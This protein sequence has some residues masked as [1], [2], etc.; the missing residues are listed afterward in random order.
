M[1]ANPVVLKWVADE[2]THR[3]LTSR[4]AKAWVLRVRALSRSRNVPLTRSICTVAGESTT[5]PRG[6]RI[7]TESSLPC[8]RS[9]FD[10]LRQA[11]ICRHHQG[12]TSQLP[13]AQRLTIGSSE[14][15][16]IAPPAITAPRQR[17]ALRA[18][19]GQSPRSFDQVGAS[20]PR[21]AGSDEAAGA[22]LHE[23]SPAFAGIDFA[24]GSVFLRDA[25]PKLVDFDE[26]EVQILT[27]RC[28][29][30]PR[31]ARWHAAAIHQSSRTCGL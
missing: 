3:R 22:I 19:D 10:G 20:A 14:D 30:R 29:S 18:G 15:G 27:R 24:G 23:T 25:G 9:M 31:H 16:R 26:R 17:L 1:G 11:H 4:L 2:P 13:R 21:R 12:G 7:S 28:S 5:S 8:S 6:A